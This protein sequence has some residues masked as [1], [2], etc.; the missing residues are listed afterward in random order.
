MR[1]RTAALILVF[2]TLTPVP[3]RNASDAAPHLGGVA[4]PPA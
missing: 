1:L 2:T 3:L 4:G